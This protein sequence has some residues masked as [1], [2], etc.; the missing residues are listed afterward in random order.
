MQ[1]ER[2]EFAFFH[3]V[4]VFP[5]LCPAAAKRKM[6]GG[7]AILLPPTAMK[8]TESIAHRGSTD[9]L[10][11]MLTRREN[12]LGFFLEKYCLLFSADGKSTHRKLTERPQ[13][14]MSAGNKDPITHA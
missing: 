3:I 5:R 10:A 2:D 8:R 13:A 6:I 11:Y 9:D 7:N 14:D 1:T 4:F 12:E